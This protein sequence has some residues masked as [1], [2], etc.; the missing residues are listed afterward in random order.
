MSLGDAPLLPEEDRLL[1]GRLQA[2]RPAAPS[3]EFLAR[4]TD[5][6]KREPLVSQEAATFPMR[7]RD[8][9]PLFKL[10]AVL[11]MVLGVLSVF[12]RPGREAVPA[13][14]QAKA[15]GDPVLETQRPVLIP[16][17]GSHAVHWYPRFDQLEDDGIVILEGNRP[18]RRVRVRMRD[19]FLWDAPEYRSSMRAEIP[20]EESLLLPIVTY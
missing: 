14:A 2:L 9:A 7:F 8:W 6:L 10:A 12:T 4:M 19:E 16:S 11:L 5:A 1:E 3:P 20:R 17:E 15:D 18:F 13:P